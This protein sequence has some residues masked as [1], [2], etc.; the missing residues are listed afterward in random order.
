MNRRVSRERQFMSVES[1]G[2]KLYR[3]TD[4]E[5][6]LNLRRAACVLPS[7]MTARDFQAW[8]KS[9]GVRGAQTYPLRWGTWANALETAGLPYHR[10]VRKG[11]Y[12]KDRIDA[13]VCLRAAVRVA[14][15]LGRIPTAQDYDEHRLPCEPSLAT[16]RK[17]LSRDQ[18]WVPIRRMVRR[19]RPDLTRITSSDRL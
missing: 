11:N 4:E 16:L 18:Q 7:P 5:L 15:E 19:V 13:Q 6:Q 12:R 10:Q 1:R 9:N 3:A 14:G 17:R 8:A 2:S